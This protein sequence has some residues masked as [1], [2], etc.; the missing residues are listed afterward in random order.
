MKLIF[1]LFLTLVLLELAQA[2]DVINCDN[3]QTSI[4]MFTNPKS[5]CRRVCKKARLEYANQFM[6]SPTSERTIL[7]C[8][9]PEWPMPDWPYISWEK[10]WTIDN[11]ARASIDLV[12]TMNRNLVASFVLTNCVWIQCK[13]RD[14]AHSTRSWHYIKHESIIELTLCGDESCE[15][16]NFHRIEHCSNFIHLLRFLPTISLKTND[17][18]RRTTRLIRWQLMF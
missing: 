1:S 9:I 3:I 10:R 6:K 2:A 15:H 18:I 7:C 8:C 12:D 5:R 4:N 14:E 17:S 11:T 13:P 16:A